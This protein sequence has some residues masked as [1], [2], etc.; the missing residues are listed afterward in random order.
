MQ[1]QETLREVVL[2]HDLNRVRFTIL[3]D[4]IYMAV[5][6]VEIS[7]HLTAPENDWRSLVEKLTLTFVLKGEGANTVNI[8]I[9]FKTLASSFSPRPV[10]DVDLLLPDNLSK[11]TKYTGGK[12]DQIEVAVSTTR[13][14]DFE[15]RV[16]FESDMI[17]G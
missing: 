5:K 4:K 2:S 9:A 11:M 17:Q 6:Q 16:F 3:Y 1:Q 8:P 7:S 14:E 12:W 13:P 15:I 10:F